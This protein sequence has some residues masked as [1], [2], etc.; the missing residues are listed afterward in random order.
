MKEQYFLT[1]YISLY[2]I[3]FDFCLNKLNNLLLIN[4]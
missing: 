2:T 3:N 4:C 1:V